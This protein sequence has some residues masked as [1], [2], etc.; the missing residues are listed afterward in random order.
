MKELKERQMA[1]S[2]HLLSRKLKMGGKKYSP[3]NAHNEKNCINSKVPKCQNLTKATKRA[4]LGGVT[5]IRSLSANQDT[6][7]LFSSLLSIR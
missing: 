2:M 7:L 5:K 4:K 3:I 6:S 1:K